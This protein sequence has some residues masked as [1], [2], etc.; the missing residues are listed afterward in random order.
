MSFEG[1]A[2]QEFSQTSYLAI[3]TLWFVF[4]GSAMPLPL[5]ALTRRY[6]SFQKSNKDASGEA[7]RLSRLNVMCYPSRVIY[8]L[9]PNHQLILFLFYPLHEFQH[10]SS[11]IRILQDH[12]NSLHYIRF[13][14]ANLTRIDVPNTLHYANCKTILAGCCIRNECSNSYA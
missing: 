3:I 1:T 8:D 6:W 7:L 11:D 5:P 4:I 13:N 2:E 10:K 9:E 14:K 12:T